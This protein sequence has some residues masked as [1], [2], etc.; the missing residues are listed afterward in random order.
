MTQIDLVARLTGWLCWSLYMADYS[1]PFGTLSWDK[2]TGRWVFGSDNDDACGYVSVSLS[3]VLRSASPRDALVAVRAGLEAQWKAEDEEAR[4]EQYA[5][6]A[7]L[8]AAETPTA[9]EWAEDQIEQ[10]REAN[11]PWLQMLR[12]GREEALAQ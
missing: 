9:Q 6:N 11:D 5:E 7:W 4:A 1:V 10:E 8:R 12:A 2:A 3:K